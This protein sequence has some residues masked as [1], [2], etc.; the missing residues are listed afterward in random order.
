MSV[1]EDQLE[2]LCLNWSRAEG[3]GTPCIVL[4]PGELRA[5]ER[6][7]QIGARP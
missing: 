2:Q 3:Y 5:G 7:H 6:D 1:I 4:L